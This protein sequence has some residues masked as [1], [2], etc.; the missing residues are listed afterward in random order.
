MG[1]QPDMI[2]SVPS[3]QTSTPGPL[4]V[5]FL[6]LP[7]LSSHNNSGRYDKVERLLKVIINTNNPMHLFGYSLESWYSRESLFPLIYWGL[8]LDMLYEAKAG[9]F[10][11]RIFSD[12]YHFCG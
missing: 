11:R 12:I 3:V 2:S 5:S 10:C 1:S 9:E 6:Y 7:K 8:H 4:P